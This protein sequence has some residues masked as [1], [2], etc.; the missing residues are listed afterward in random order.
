M[1]YTPPAHGCGQDADFA[2][3]TGILQP[4]CVMMIE[5]GRSGGGGGSGSGEHRYTLFVPP[6]ERRE[7]VWN[8]ERIGVEAA[9]RF[10]GADAAH[11]VARCKLTVYV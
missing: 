11:E 1:L 7:E 8:G 3:L 9:R 4:N 10:F 6:Y 2:Y 5:K